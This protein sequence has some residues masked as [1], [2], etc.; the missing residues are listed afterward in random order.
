MGVC[1]FIAGLVSDAFGYF[2]GG[3]TGEQKQKQRTFDVLHEPACYIRYRRSNQKHDTEASGAR[4][5]GS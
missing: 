5:S 1:Q 3:S 4:P 2:T